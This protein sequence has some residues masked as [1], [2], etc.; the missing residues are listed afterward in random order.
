SRGRWGR[1]DRAASAGRLVRGPTGE[2]RLTDLRNLRRRDR[3]AVVPLP[4]SAGESVRRRDQ[5]GPDAE[6]VASQPG[7]AAPDPGGPIGAGGLWI[8]G[9]ASSR[10]AHRGAFRR[11]TR[12][13]GVGPRR[14]TSDAPL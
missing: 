10:T 14:R 5:R 1:V 2:R 9:A 12:P 6:A 11:P 3:L 7:S 13:Q 8:T 4:G